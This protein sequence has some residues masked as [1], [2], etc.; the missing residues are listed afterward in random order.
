MT[1]RVRVE[2]LDADD[3]VADLVALARRTRL[4]PL[5]GARQRPGRGARRRAR[6]AG[7]RDRA[8]AARAA[9]PL[10]DLVQQVPTVPES[11]DGDELLTRLRELRPRSWPWWS[12][13][14]AAPRASS[15]SRT[16]SRRSSA[17]SATST[18]APSRPA[19]ARS[20]AAAGWCPGCCATTRWPTPP[21]SRCRRATTRRS[22]ASSW[23]GSGASPT[24]A[25]SVAVDGWRLTVMR[26]DRNR[27]AELRLRPAAAPKTA[28]TDRAGEVA[29]GLSD[30]LALLAAVAL[31]A[32]NA[33]FV[34]AEFALISARRDRLE[35]M[36]DAGTAAAR[37]VL[38]ADADLSRML[39]ASQLG[40]HDL[41][42][43]ARP[44]R[45]A[46][47]RAPDRAPAGLGEAARGPAAPASPSRSRWRS[48]WSR[49]SCSARWCPRTSRSPGRSA[50]RSCWSR[51]SW[52]SPP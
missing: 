44:A 30:L 31:L 22:P 21:A 27:I 37:T 2:S 12:T 48:S 41:L 50:P 39:A 45:R 25:T 18:T 13:S 8:V 46:G 35:A 7:V 15:P 1:P 16:S 6:Q 49:T 23:P 33:F 26:R 20:G 29:R 17:T 19:S 5:P 28:V 9:S 36:A 42:A 14:T 38:R 51:R 11:L 52:C 47:R 10:R 3:T 34:G 40:H 32:A 4:L 43:A 24:S